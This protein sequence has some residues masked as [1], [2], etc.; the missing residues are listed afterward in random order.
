MTS[1]TRGV[2]A[3]PLTKKRAYGKNSSGKAGA[4]KTVKVKRKRR[5]ALSPMAVIL[6]VCLA[7][8][9]IMLLLKMEYISDKAAIA[10][11]GT[12]YAVL[13][14]MAVGVFFVGL[15]EL[16]RPRWA[17]TITLLLPM[18]FFAFYFTTQCLLKQTYGNYMSYSVMT[19]T[20]GDLVG[21]YSTEIWQTIIG[22]LG[23][24]AL[25][26]WPLALCI[27]L[28]KWLIMPGKSKPLRFAASAALSL[29]MTAGGIFMIYNIPNG[30]I[31]DKQ[32]FTSQFSMNECVPRFGMTLSAAM[33]VVYTYVEKPVDTGVNADLPIYA[34]SLDVYG[35]ANILDI[36]FNAVGASGNSTIASMSR[37]FASQP[38]TP[39]N[40]YTGIFAGKNLIMIC[41]ESLNINMITPEITP[42]LYKLMTE[43]FHFTDFYQPPWGVSTSDGEYSLTMGLIPK[44]GVNS[45][46]ASRK[47]N[48]Y[49]TMGN[50]LKRLGY[51][52]YG[53]H[54]NSY[55]YYNRNLTH[56][57]LGYDVWMGM[58]NG[59][60]KY[61]KKIWPASDREM[62]NATLPFYA[63]SS[64]F[65]A[66][67]MTVSG[68]L[69]Y[70]F[71]G[72]NMAARNKQAVISLN[73]PDAVKAY[74]ACNLELEYALTDL[75][76]G[77][78]E[79]GILDDTVIALC[80]D[81]YPYGLSAEN[82]DAL[83]GRYLERDFEYYKNVCIIYNS[84]TPAVEVDKPCYSIDILP[85]LLNLFGVEYDSRLLMGKD[86]L[87]SFEGLVIFR[88]YSWISEKGRYNARTGVFT[89]AEGAVIEDTAAYIATMNAVVR[90]RT[91]YSRYILDY[92]YFEYVF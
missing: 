38:G 35:Y 81:H 19:Q 13:F 78:E 48:N 46:Y 73:Y 68:H 58:G 60:E 65:M 71:S 45:M 9:E 1:G 61:V 66:Y 26:F 14:P 43:G 18:G 16:M 86:M 3:A 27:I 54:N 67:Y 53:Y 22:G 88:N 11:L 77:L 44:S 42:T 55:T 89:P 10:N 59:M 23:E 30:Y 7:Y 85:T 79:K 36:D 49:F 28:S 25:F 32:Y 34:P 90:N 31:T 5:D 6:P 64:P 62:M 8:M 56:K 87:S 2:K 37:F 82:T 91:L 52:T 41:A 50:S 47:N 17:K 76:A 63:D 15:S 80:P 75:L 74:I 40:E 83:A 57:N 70:S 33:D 92:D 21:S 24:I 20:A 12:L 29:V 39:K 72:N 69:N 84:A 51:S 4:K